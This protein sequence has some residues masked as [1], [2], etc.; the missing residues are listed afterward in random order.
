MRVLTGV[1]YIGGSPSQDDASTQSE[2]GGAQGRS[3]TNPKA[4]TKGK[5]QKHASR[6]NMARRNTS[7][8][9]AKDSSS[10][11]EL[12]QDSANKRRKLSR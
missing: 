11:E 7:K 4:N 6:E 5:E 1:M 3:T 12:D 10:D 9:P 8:R 2:E